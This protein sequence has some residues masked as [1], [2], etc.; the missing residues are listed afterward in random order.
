MQRVYE[1]NE[2][3]KVSKRIVTETQSSTLADQLA[4]KKTLLE[5]PLALQLAVQGSRSKVNATATAQLQYQEI[6]EDRTFN[7]INLNNYDIILG[8]P[9]MHQHQICIGFNPA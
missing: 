8:T 1:E 5:V 3:G 7:I 9:W 2:W 6:K 4:V